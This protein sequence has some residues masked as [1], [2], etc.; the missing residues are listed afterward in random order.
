MEAEM[1]LKLTNLKTIYGELSKTTLFGFR[2]SDGNTNEVRVRMKSLSDILETYQ[3]EVEDLDDTV[4]NGQR[5]VEWVD[6]KNQLFTGKALLIQLLDA[7]LTSSPSFNEVTKYKTETP[8][9]LPP[10]DILKFRGDW[11]K[12]AHHR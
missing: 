9:R 11:Q 2:T 7:N 12:G 4:D 3:T 1:A 10:V 5:I 8:M 6:I